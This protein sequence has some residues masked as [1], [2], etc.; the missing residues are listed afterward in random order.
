MSGRM[1]CPSCNGTLSAS[2]G[3]C[4]GMN[5]VYVYSCAQHDALMAIWRDWLKQ[6]MAAGMNNCTCD[7][8]SLYHAARAAGIQSEREE[9]T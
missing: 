3:T 1:R 5:V 9:K 6:N 7:T 4:D 2:C 8:C